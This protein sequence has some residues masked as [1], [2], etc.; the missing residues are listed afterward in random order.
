MSNKKILAV[1][2][3]GT[4][5][6]DDKSIAK[7]NLEAL[8]KMLDSGHILAVDT[9]RPGHVL[10][11]VLERYP[12][13]FRENVYFLSYQGSVGYCPSS[14]ETFYGIYLDNAKAIDLLNKIHASGLTALAFEEGAIYCFKENFDTEEYSRLS[15]EKLTLIKDA[16]ELKGHNLVKLMAVSFDKHELLHKF[17]ADNLKDTRDCFDNM[18]SNVSFLEYISTKSGKDVG[19]TK[20]ANHLNIDM[21]DTIAC[22]DERNDIEMIKTAGVGAAVKNGR[23]ELKAVADYITSEDNNHGA[24]ADVINKFVLNN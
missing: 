24:V 23:E 1:D 19:L 4:L 14:K 3:D 17:E 10:E 5:F 20:L 11:K 9:G 2:L 16:N 7:V 8:N 6:T 12:V 22:G 18:F 15:K 13:F 21:S